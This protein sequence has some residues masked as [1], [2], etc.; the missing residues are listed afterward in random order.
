MDPSSLTNRLTAMSVQA[1]CVFPTR[2]AVRMR[3]N[4][5]H[6]DQKPAY[7]KPRP[8]SD[9]GLPSLLMGTSISA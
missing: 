1:D 3:D 2:T 8:C 4:R 5:T 6:S 7:T 9:S